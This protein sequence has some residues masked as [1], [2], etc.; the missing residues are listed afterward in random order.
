MK[1]SGPTLAGV[2][3]T[4]P[5]TLGL[6]DTNIVEVCRVVHQAGGLV[7][8]DGANMNALLGPDQARKPGVRR[9]PP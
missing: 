4:L 8:G 1:W 5:S 2:M 9:G 6:F 7:Y 3:I